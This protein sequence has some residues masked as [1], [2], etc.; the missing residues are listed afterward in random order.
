MRPRR[1]D[2]LQPELVKKFPFLL[3]SPPLVQKKVPVRRGPYMRARMYLPAE[4]LLLELP[5][6]VLQREPLPFPDGRMGV[7]A[8]YGTKTLKGWHRYP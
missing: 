6:A 1:G 3:G 2:M 4:R 7:G 8:D 5:K